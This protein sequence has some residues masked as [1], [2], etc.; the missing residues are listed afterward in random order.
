MYSLVKANY[1]FDTKLREEIET[2]RATKA[3]DQAEIS[4]IVHKQ[5]QELN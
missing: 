3:N 1:S 2:L 5:G 4:Q